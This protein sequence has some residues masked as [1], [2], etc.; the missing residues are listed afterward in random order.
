MAIWKVLLVNGGLLEPRRRPHWPFCHH[1]HKQQVD[2]GCRTSRSLIRN[3][4][5]HSFPDLFRNE[6]LNSPSS[7]LVSDVMSANS[8]H[9][10]LRIHRSSNILFRIPSWSMRRKDKYVSNREGP[11]SSPSISQPCRFPCLLTI[12]LWIHMQPKISSPQSS[13]T[14]FGVS[15]IPWIL[16]QKSDSM[17]LASIM[18]STRS[19]SHCMWI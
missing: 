11:N 17:R 3:F 1:K 7:S 10:I 13:I 16:L 18:A 2:I 5:G 14:W 12:S 9:N 19:P 8:T 6:N 15:I 4:T